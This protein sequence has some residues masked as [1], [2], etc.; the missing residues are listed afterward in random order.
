MKLGKLSLAAI[1][2]ASAL[3]SIAGASSLEEAIKGVTINGFVRYRYTD[4]TPG[5]DSH[6]YKGVFKVGVPVNEVI[7][8]K[9]KSVVVGTLDGQGGDANPGYVLA[10]VYG[11]YSGVEGL[12]LQAGKQGIP[13][14]FTDA[15]D[16]RGTGLVALYNAGPVTLAAGGL[17]T[18]MQKVV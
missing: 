13:G 14:P 18:L 12:T 6:Q 7:T 5:D 16:Q 15:A 17:L 8:L 4:M 3:T 9:T 1:V 11:V 10:D 2:A